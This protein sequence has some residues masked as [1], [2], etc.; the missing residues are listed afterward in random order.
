MHAQACASLRKLA[1]ACR[2]FMLAEIMLAGACLASVQ[3]C[4]SL[5]KLAVQACASMPCKH[6]VQACSASMIYFRKGLRKACYV[7]KKIE[8]LAIVILICCN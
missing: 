5:H 8:M 4:A 1:E 6:T 7:H 2:H 3:A